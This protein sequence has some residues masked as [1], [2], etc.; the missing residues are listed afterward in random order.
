[1]ESNIRNDLYPHLRR[2]PVSFHAEW[3]SG[4]LLYRATTDLSTIRKFIGY[5]LVYLVVN[6]ATF[7]WVLAVLLHL[8]LALGLVTGAAAVPIL[9]TG[10]NFERSY[11]S[12]AR[13]VQDLQGDLTTLVGRRPGASG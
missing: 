4:Q 10:R 7:I 6:I 2:L 13:R 9:I 5:E 8:N 1:M 11:H 12:K 3:Q